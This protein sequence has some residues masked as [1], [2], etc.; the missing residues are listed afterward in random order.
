MS[1][2]S[3]STGW[4]WDSQTNLWYVYSSLSDEIIYATGARVARPSQTPPSTY[5]A[6]AAR[7]VEAQ[8][9]SNQS[10]QSR[11]GHSSVSSITGSR[12][13]LYPVRSNHAPQSQ[14]SNPH[15]ARRDSQSSIPQLTANIASLRVGSSGSSI[16]RQLEPNITISKTG[17]R[18]ID[19]VDNASEVQTSYVEEER[20]AHQTTDPS[21]R[22]EG[23]SARRLVLAQPNAEEGEAERLYPDYKVRKS[24]FFSV[25]RVFLILWVE[26][27]GGTVVTNAQRVDKAVSVGRYNENV[28]SKVRRFVVIRTAE[29]YCSALPIT[30]YGGKG[31]GK[32]GVVK[33]EHAIIY[34]G[35]SPPDATPSELPRRNEDGMR[36]QPIR[37][38]GDEREDVL[39]TMSRV[40]F[41]KVHTI[42]HNIKV[43]PFGK[44]V[45]QSLGALDTQFTNVWRKIPDSG[46]SGIGSSTGRPRSAT[47]QSQ[48]RARG[49][50]IASRTDSSRS[51]GE[52]SGASATGTSHAARETA[53][54]V[55][56]T[57]AQLRRG[58]TATEQAIA[59]VVQRLADNGQNS[60]DA[61]IFVRDQLARASQLQS[62][63]ARPTAGAQAASGSNDA[64][65]DDDDDDH[66]EDEE[67]E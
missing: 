17:A 6:L 44:V 60:A 28:H 48:P 29:K 57:F 7:T 53:Q 65:S 36:S 38:S 22:S 18:R 32:E 59:N 61:E 2:Q 41:G 37:V 52:I 58:G 16:P 25:G 46:D 31:V 54:W 24:S 1:E 47:S 33:S 8:P 34:T 9:R 11:T 26:P 62:R 66:D 4:I 20:P 40:D 43:K 13:D 10:A 67:S 19:V 42:Q 14:R 5:Y 64:D 21:L 45:Q 15:Q 39:D 55:V 3:G 51:A 50:T 35:R 30:S 49:S 23:V 12:S 27:A 56:N 63:A